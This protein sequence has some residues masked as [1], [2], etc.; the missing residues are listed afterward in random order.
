MQ[1]QIAIGLRILK[2]TR[3]SIDFVMLTPTVKPM[4]KQTDSLK[5]RRSLKRMSSLR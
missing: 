5:Q 1:T 2:P 4:L 3:E